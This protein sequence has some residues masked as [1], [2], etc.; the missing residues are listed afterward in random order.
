MNNKN[1]DCKKD[2]RYKIVNE[3]AV[4]YNIEIPLLVWAGMS[5]RELHK[6]LEEAKKEEVSE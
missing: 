2:P 4:K 3:L 1:Y 5:L 6:I